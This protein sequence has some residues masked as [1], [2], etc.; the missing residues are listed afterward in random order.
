MDKTLS[1]ELII[2]NIIKEY[3][4]DIFNNSQ[5]LLALIAD[6]FPNNQKVKRLLTISIKENIPSQ[7]MEIITNK[8]G[9]YNIAFQSVR[10][11][12]LDV[13]MENQ[14]FTEQILRIWIFAIDNKEL[15]DRYNL[16]KNLELNNSSHN[17]TIELIPQEQKKQFEKIIPANYQDEYIDNLYKQA[18]Q[19]KINKELDKAIFLYQKAAELGDRRSM[20]DI[21][22]MYFKGVGVNKN[23]ETALFWFEKAAKFGSIDSMLFL[24]SIYYRGDNVAI[25][26]KKS[27]YWNQKANY[28][29]R[30]NR[31]K[32]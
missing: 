25:D 5:K 23:I 14:E 29:I 32:Y 28:M 24:S 4:I 21:G 11:K 15:I 6:Y 19:H 13:F 20:N 27:R 2:C 16:H 30:K 3:G 10:Y 26:K 17:K 7:I 12:L 8:K 1:P 9:D 22:Y 31:A 18:Y